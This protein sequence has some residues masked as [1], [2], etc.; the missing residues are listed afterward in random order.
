MK[1]PAEEIEEA[2]LGLA[3]MLD[4]VLL[5]L[6]FFLVT[7]SFTSPRIGL[8]LPEALTGE[9][10]AVP[11]LLVT[12]AEDGALE[13]DGEAIELPALEQRIQSFAREADDP[14]LVVRADDG[15]LHGR[16]VEVLDLSRAQGITQVGIEVSAPKPRA[17]STSSNA[18]EPEAGP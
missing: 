18:S 13:L 14:E 5:L 7:T 11:Q 17:G 15:A 1:L 16:V 12:I 2:Q 3:P 6:I 9:I 8:E 4:V 10:A